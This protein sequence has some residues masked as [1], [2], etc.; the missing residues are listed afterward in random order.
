MTKFMK[1]KDM[2]KNSKHTWQEL[3]DFLKGRNIALFGNAQ[4]VLDKPKEI[5]T[6]YEIICRMN[7]GLPKNNEK[8]IGKRTDILFL[9]VPLT[10]ARL[11]QINPK[12]V[13]WCTPKKYQITKWL[14][15]NALMYSNLDWTKLF[16][17][18]KHRP[19]TGIMALDILLHT[20]FKTITLYGF[21]HW[22]TGTWYINR[23]HLAQ[24]NPKAEKEYIET[25]I[26]QYKGK[27]IKA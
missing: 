10:K 13:I 21:D 3:F 8:Y 23:K 18:L 9:S 16:N 22:K 20:E 6:K 12:F 19:S 11:E 24:H 27:I 25:L 5:D 1:K 17:I 14:K 15:N 4:S 2:E 7:F 26:K